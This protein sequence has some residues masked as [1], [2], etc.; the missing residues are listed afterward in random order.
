MNGQDDDQATQWYFQGN[1]RL[2]AKVKADKVSGQIEF[3]TRAPAATSN[4]YGGG[5]NVSTRR[6]FGVWSFSDNAWLK[7]GK[8]HLHAHR[9]HFQPVFRR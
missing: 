5:T 3:A 7:V 4:G 9:L 2:G 1:S 8:Y 6:A